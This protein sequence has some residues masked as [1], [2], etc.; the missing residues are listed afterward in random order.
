MEYPCASPTERRWFVVRVRRVAEGNL[1]MA[2]VAHEN[3][4]GR[5]LLREQ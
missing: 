5:K 1:P 3:I 4:T 2:V